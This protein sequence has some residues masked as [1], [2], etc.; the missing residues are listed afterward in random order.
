MEVDARQVHKGRGAVSN[1]AG[2]FE[3]HQL[4]PFDDGW[5]TLEREPI[6]VPK[7]TVSDDASRTIINKNNSPDIPFDLSINPY[8]GCEHGCIY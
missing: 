1:R 5:G 4:E 3:V 2:R 6:Q 8:K 7:T